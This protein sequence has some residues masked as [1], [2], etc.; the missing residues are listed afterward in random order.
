MIINYDE[1]IF[2]FGQILTVNF[3]LIPILK[4]GGQVDYIVA[5]GRDITALK[6]TE[7]AL[8][9]QTNQLETVNG[10]LEA[11]S[12]SVSHDLRAPL[13][14]IHGYTKMLE[15]DYVSQLDD[16]AKNLLIS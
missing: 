16:E 12:Y 11:F 8:L 10:E 3:S 15:E 4:Q 2:A 9:K 6:A 13:R 14:A 1:N 5:E 7:T